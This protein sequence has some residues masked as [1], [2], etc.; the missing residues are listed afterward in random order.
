MNLASEL[1]ITL[2]KGKEKKAIKN[3][4]LSVERDNWISIYEN[5]ESIL[6][7]KPSSNMDLNIHLILNRLI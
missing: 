1:Y 7:E 5:I 3:S 6:N 4:P 2:S